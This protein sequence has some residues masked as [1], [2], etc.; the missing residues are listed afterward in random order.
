M[1][2]FFCVAID[3][4][5][6]MAARAHSL[7]ASGNRRPVEAGSHKMRCAACGAYTTWKMKKSR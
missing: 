3:D 4:K 2:G 7:S 5:M 1:S 6:G